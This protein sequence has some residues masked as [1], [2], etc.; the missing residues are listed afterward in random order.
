MDLPLVSVIV[1]CYNV[2][3][4][5]PKCVDSILSQTYTNLEIILVDDGSPDHCGEIC[6]EYARKDNRIRV[7]HKK[8]GGLSDARNV[9]IDVAKGEYI[10]FVDSD[11]W[12]ADNYV[13]YLLQLAMQNQSNLSV[14]QYCL[15]KEYKDCAISQPKEYVECFSPIKAI[16]RMFYQKGIEISATGKL[17]HKSLFETGIRYPKGL[18]F[19]DNPV[20]FRLFYKSNRVVVSNQLLYFYLIRSNSIEGSL[21]NQRKMDCAVEIMKMMYDYPEITNQVVSAF[22]CKIVSLAFHFVLKMPS[23]NACTQE[24]YQFIVRYRRQ[25]LFDFQARRKTQ[26]AC[27]I[28]F[29]GLFITQAIFR[30]I[31]KRR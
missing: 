7:I 15:F 4:Y 19:E 25:I 14:V 31:D 5:L 3:A 21:F 29:L 11:D 28:S 10:T 26:L 6:E 24:L 8:N 2:E 30:K 23:N 13:E 27:L 18:M 17:Y 22:R 12:V 1:P 16:C 9:A 20:T